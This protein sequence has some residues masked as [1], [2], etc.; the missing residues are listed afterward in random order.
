MKA[1]RYRNPYPN[2]QLIEDLILQEGLLNRPRE[3]IPPKQKKSLKIFL[4]A[5]AVIVLF[6][7][8]GLLIWEL[9]KWIIN[10]D[11]TASLNVLLIL[12][13]VGVMIAGWVKSKKGG[14]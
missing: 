10:A 13:G 3:V 2:H 1:K 9:L 5:V 12:F 14:K 11:G 7:L 6:L 8:A 4:I